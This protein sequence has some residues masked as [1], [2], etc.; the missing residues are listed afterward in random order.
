[1]RKVLTK[2]IALRRPRS[3]QLRRVLNL[4]EVLAVIV[5][6]LNLAPSIAS[7][8]FPQADERGWM[9]DERRVP[10]KT[11]QATISLLVDFPRAIEVHEEEWVSSFV[12]VKGLPAGES[13]DVVLEMRALGLSVL[14][15]A[16]VRKTVNTVNGETF[17]VSSSTPGTKRYVVTA[18]FQ[19]L[20]DGSGKIEQRISVRVYQKT[21]WLV[22]IGT[23][24]QMLGLPALLTAILIELFRRRLGSRDSPK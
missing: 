3:Q 18:A 23:M 1:M 19:G 6:A 5:I 15:S 13:V 14:P 4:A 12:E 20:P 21:D 9:Y 22:R 11:G 2:L 7:R 10:H 24:V 16:P 8:L 17:F